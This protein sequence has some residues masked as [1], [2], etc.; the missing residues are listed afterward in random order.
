MNELNILG[1][2]GEPFGIEIEVRSITSTTAAVFWKFSSA[3]A[4]SYML[5]DPI[6]VPPRS[7]AV[8]ERSTELLDLVPGWLYQIHV[9]PFLGIEVWSSSKIGDPLSITFETELE[10]PVLTIT[11]VGDNWVLG[12][13]SVFGRV[14]QIEVNLLDQQNVIKSKQVS[15]S[16]AMNWR[17]DELLDMQNYSVVTKVSTKEQIISSETL[18]FKTKPSFP[19]LRSQA[20]NLDDQTVEVILDVSI[21]AAVVEFKIECDGTEEAHNETKTSLITFETTAEQFACIFRTRTIGFS[22]NSQWFVFK[23]GIAILEDFQISKTSIVGKSSTF[24]GMS[25]QDYIPT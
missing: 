21:R 6:D 17:F 5:I 19:Y 10:K 24:H 2:G 22:D 16:A 11:E 1:D 14:S 18:T 7:F 9:F 13:I 4:S 25:G 12:N 20:V 8:Q 23:V 15:E 3:H